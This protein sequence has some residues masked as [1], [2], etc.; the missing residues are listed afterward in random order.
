MRLGILSVQPTFRLKI[1]YHA[2]KPS[3]FLNDISGVIIL[4]VRYGAWRRCKQRHEFLFEIKMLYVP[5]FIV[6]TVMSVLYGYIQIWF[7][8]YDTLS[9]FY[10]HFT[11]Q[12]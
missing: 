6:Q 10:L 5:A 8:W 3:T 12:N 9:Y 4:N 7:R 1:W 11:K 2:E